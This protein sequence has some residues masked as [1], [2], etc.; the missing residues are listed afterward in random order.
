M[1]L[2]LIADLHLDINKEYPV[3]E[4]LA[5]ILKEKEADGLI[6]AGDISE[7]SG[8]T[9]REAEKLEREA[10]CPVW[11]VPG[12]HDMWST[13]FAR[14]S[15][16]QIYA[17]YAADPR[18]LVDKR[19]DLHGDNGPVCLVGDIG[20]YDYSFASNLYS[21]DELEQMSHGGRTWQDK[22]KNQWT[23]DNRGRMQ[24]MVDK[25]EK[26]LRSC[27]ER[28]VIAVTHML[29]VDDFCVPE[30]RE[31]WDY[32][33]AFL[34]GSS[35]GRLYE[36]FHVTHAVCGHVHFRKKVRRHGITYHCPCLGYH[37]EWERFF[38]HGD[39][40]AWQIGETLQW[41]EV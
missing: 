41:I 15:T 34:G 17:D 27:G 23:A 3:R 14:R 19:V 40:A 30:E 10:D 22:L 25:L 37:T 36:R 4:I 11:Y 1:K 26:K 12:N 21:A 16:D 29:P 35:L 39:D 5:A 28:P 33:N 6:V 13:D 38:H 20:W 31:G 9:M 7:D 2:A 18:C 32:F 24:L 8:M